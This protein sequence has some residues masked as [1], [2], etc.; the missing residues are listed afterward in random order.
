MLKEEFKI[1]RQILINNTA[2]YMVTD[3]E[4][5]NYSS[6]HGWYIKH[7]EP[8]KR[9]TLSVENISRQ[10]ALNLIKASLI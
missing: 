1:A 6:I 8:V 7:L 10:A 2:G 9:V 3:N 5:L 4:P